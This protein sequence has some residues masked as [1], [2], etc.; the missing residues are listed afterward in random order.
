M[1]TD[2][3]GRAALSVRS[4]LQ[5]SEPQAKA[6]GLPENRTARTAPRNSESKTAIH[7]DARGVVKRVTI[8]VAVPA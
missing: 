6:I 3:T 7:G 4:E 5:K 1:N 2:T 8:D